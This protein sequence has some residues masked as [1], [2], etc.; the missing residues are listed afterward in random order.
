MIIEVQHVL[1]K[2]TDVLHQL[3]NELYVKPCKNLDNA[4]IGQHTRHIIELFEELLSGYHNGTV[5]YDKRKRDLLIEKD[6]RNALNH[7]NNIINGVS[8][9][10]K[11][12]ILMQKAGDEVLTVTTNYYRELLY[13]VEHCIHH[14]AL[15]KVALKDMEEIII[16]EH[17]GVAYATIAYRN[18]CAQ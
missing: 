15:I 9:P 2:L 14:Q 4:S 18:Q 8:L 3:T 12:L 11:T 17:F 6:T 1:N 13:N 5:N 10:D 16:H 7:I